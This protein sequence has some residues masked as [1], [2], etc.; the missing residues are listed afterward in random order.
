MNF[1]AHIEERKIPRHVI[2]L[3]SSR[4]KGVTVTADYRSLSPARQAYPDM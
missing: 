2:V 4:A 1:Y 3:N